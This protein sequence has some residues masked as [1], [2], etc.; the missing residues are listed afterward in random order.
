[1][2]EA[3]DTWNTYL[4]SLNLPRVREVGD[5]LNGLANPGQSVGPAV[6]AAASAAGDSGA[7]A[8]F[9]VM[10]GVA[11]GRLAGI[12]PSNPPAIGMTAA[13]S[14][15]R[16]NDNDRAAVDFLVTLAGSTAGPSI[17]AAPVGLDEEEDDDD[18][19]NGNANANDVND[20]QPPTKR[21]RVDDGEDSE[22]G[23]RGAII[24]KRK[25]RATDW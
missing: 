8:P 7:P 25:Q 3:L 11:V 9:A 16:M 22:D 14:V 21:R 17:A 15:Y 1:M 24:R 20:D 10:A 18:D 23:R 12:G 6:A 5:G 13:A 2:N 19:T 4:D